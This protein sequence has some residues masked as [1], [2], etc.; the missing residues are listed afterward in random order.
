MFYVVGLIWSCHTHGHL[1]QCVQNL[2]ESETLQIYLFNF[3]FILLFSY[4]ICVWCIVNIFFCVHLCEVKGHMSMCMLVCGGQRLV[5]S[6]FILC[7]SSEHWIGTYQDL[8]VDTRVLSQDPVFM[9]Q[10]LYKQC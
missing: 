8:S 1:L 3:L 2:G 5:L 9:G 4:L 10:G 7:L 6:V